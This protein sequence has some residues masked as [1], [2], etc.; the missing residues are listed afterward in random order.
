MPRKRLFPPPQHPQTGKPLQNKGPQEY[1]V[2]TVND[3]IVLKRRRWSAPGAGSTTPLDAWLDTAEATVSLGVRELACR[4]NQGGRNFDKAAENLARAARVHLSGELLRQLVAAEG[5]AV[6][7]AQQAGTLALGWTAADCRV[8]ETAP[9]P[10]ESPS[11][12][13]PGPATRAYLGVDGVKVPL[14]TDAEKQARR[15]KVKQKRRRRGR[16][17]RPLPKA[18]RGADQRYKEFKIVTYYDE[19]QEHRHVA[20]TAGDHRVAGALM[21]RDAAR[22]ALDRA[23]DKVAVVDGADWIRKQLGRQSLPLDAVGLD[24]YHL[25]DNVH[26][27]R[28]VVYGDEDPA[29]RE[30]AAGVLHVAKHEGYEALRDEL[31]AWQGRLRSRRKRQA[32]AQLLGYVTERRAMILYPEFVVAGRQIGSGPTESMCKAT[33]QRLKGS[34]MRWDADNAEAVMALEALDQSGEWEQYWASYL[35]PAA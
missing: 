24:F 16:K 28:R 35:K 2:L 12:A 21:R 10:A 31:V 14:V 34:G 11:A 17:C 20:V 32:A 22:I 7:A 33:T 13:R 23:D 5:R 27:A 25:A 6:Q 30:W 29:G 18:K 1:S 8:P 3:R 19:G 4:L 9:P 15:H 26:K